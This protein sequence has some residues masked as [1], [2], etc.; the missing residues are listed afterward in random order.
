MNDDDGYKAIV[1]TRSVTGRCQDESGALSQRN[2]RISQWLRKRA[3]EAR[4]WGCECVVCYVCEGT[5]AAHHI[6]IEHLRH[7]GI[8]GRGTQNPE[9]LGRHREARW[10]GGHRC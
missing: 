8:R 7:E 10:P 4:Y 2:Q 1:M 5:V 9:N 6:F 3:S